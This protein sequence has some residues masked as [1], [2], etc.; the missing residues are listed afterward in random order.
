MQIMLALDGH[1]GTGKTTLAENLAKA[2]GGKYI[3]PYGKP[4]GPELLKASKANNF[5]KIL[6]IGKDAYRRATSNHTDGRPLVFDRL[7]IT[8]FTLLPDSLQKDWIIRPPTAVCWIDFPT[9]LA[10]IS[11]RDEERYPAIWHKYYIGLYKKLAQKYNCELINTME[12]NQAQALEKLIA[13]AHS[14]IL[15]YRWF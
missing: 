6:K 4:F 5:E 3:R 7:W 15:S 8:L 10:R 14:T 2:L 9:T 11:R 12:S 1:D 13:W